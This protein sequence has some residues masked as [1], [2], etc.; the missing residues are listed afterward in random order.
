LLGV[1]KFFMNFPL[2][3]WQA[4]IRWFAATKRQW[5]Q[6]WRSWRR[7]SWWLA[8][9]LTGVVLASC[10]AGGEASED[11]QASAEF[12][13]KVL[14]VLRDNPQVLMET[15]QSYQQEQQQG[16]RQARRSFLEKMS[17]EPASIIGNSPTKGSAKQDIVLLEFSDFQCPFCRRAYETV[18]QF[19]EKHQNRVTL[20]YK[21]LPLASIHP[22][23]VPAAQASWAAQQQGKF[24]EYHDRLFENQDRLGEELYKQIATELGLDMDA[25]NRDRNSEAA[26]Q[27]IQKDLQLAQRLGLNRTPFFFLNE[28]ALSGAIEL[29]ELEQALQRVGS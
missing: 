5:Q 9:V 26:Q 1:G 28:Q 16:M 13:Q 6:M 18:K 2:Y 4:S 27:A 7:L 19:M 23:A 10:S 22:Q 8:A 24:W 11:T 21:H 14:Q 12:E 15:L 3:L 20:V 25:W 29:S 17:K